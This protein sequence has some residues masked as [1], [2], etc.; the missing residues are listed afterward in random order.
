[1]IRDELGKLI[2]E[3]RAV[4]GVVGLGY[5]GLPLIVEFS[6]KGMKGIGF[7]VDL[8]PYSKLILPPFLPINFVSEEEWG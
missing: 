2:A 1:M 5:V 6:L 3:K 8:Y 4:I 7:E